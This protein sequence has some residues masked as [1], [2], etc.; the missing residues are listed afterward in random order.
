MARSTRPFATVDRPAVLRALEAAGSR[1]PDVLH[2]QK[3][4]LREAAAG[5]KL[6]GTVLVW[7]GG[8]ATLTIVLAPLGIPAL[9]LGI[10]LRRRGAANLANVEAGFAEFLS[11]PER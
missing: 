7:A 2:A 9:W 3:Q 4:A 1:D 6:L 5:P 10:W 11:H 8:I